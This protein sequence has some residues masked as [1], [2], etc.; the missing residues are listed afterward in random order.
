MADFTICLTGHTGYVGSHF[1][2]FLIKSGRRPFII[3][4]QNSKIE[5]ITGC[6]TAEI[7]ENSTDLTKQLSVLKNPIIINIAGYFASDHKSVNLKN[8]IDSNFNYPLTIMEAISDIRDPK[9]VNIGTNWE[10]DEIGDHEPANLY[11]QLKA[12]NADVSEWYVKNYGFKVIHLKLN[13]TFGGKD[14]RTKLMPLLKSHYKN[15]TVAELNFSS[16]IINLLHISDVCHGLLWAAKRTNGFLPGTSETAFLLAKENV[17]L[18]E[19]VKKINNLAPEKLYANF[20]GDYPDHKSLR[21]I[22]N[23]APL[24]A[25]WHQVM[26]LDQALKN[27]FLE[28]SK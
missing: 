4:R 5:P 3:G 23:E 17:S 10:F 21:T 1:I 19:L 2:D 11:A 8:L 9:I 6:S 12:C 20:Q 27:Y 13:D 26:E 24:L 16:Q 25:G 15:R 28:H 7:W 14:N 18:L 22:W